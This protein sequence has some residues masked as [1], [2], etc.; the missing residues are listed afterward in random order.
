MDGRRSRAHGFLGAGESGSRSAPSHP[1]IIHGNDKSTTQGRSQGHQNPKGQA[2]TKPSISPGCF[3]F[4]DMSVS[5]SGHLVIQPRHLLGE[6]I[7]SS[8]ACCRQNAYSTYTAEL[9]YSYSCCSKNA[10]CPEEV[11]DD[12]LHSFQRVYGT[13]T[14][15]VEVAHHGPDRTHHSAPQTRTFAPTRRTT[16]QQKLTH[17]MAAHLQ[18]PVAGESATTPAESCPVTEQSRR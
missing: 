5:Y 14:Y 8:P 7:S 9:Q 15:T 6:G 16:M 10:P 3:F 1:Q 17:L 12:S 2:E 18:R 13:L 11:A 4:P